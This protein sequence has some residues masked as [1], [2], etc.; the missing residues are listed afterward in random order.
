MDITRYMD[1]SFKPIPRHSPIPPNGVACVHGTYDTP[2]IPD[3]GTTFIICKNKQEL[4]I[5]GPPLREIPGI[6][7]MSDRDRSITLEKRFEEYLTIIVSVLRTAILT[8]DNPLD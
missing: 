7:H 5:E 6:E 8:T 4:L 2:D 3:P 1:L